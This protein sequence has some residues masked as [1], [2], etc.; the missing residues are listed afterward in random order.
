MEAGVAQ[1]VERGIC[2]PAVVGSSPT[3]SSSV[4]GGVAERSKAGD[5][6]SPGL[7]PCAGSN[8]AP[9]TMEA[10]VAQLVEQR[11]S[12]PQVAGSSPVARSMENKN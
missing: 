10:G 7:T 2:N 11:P 4:K 12:K 6:K 5:C 1:L 3:A 9:S 8:P